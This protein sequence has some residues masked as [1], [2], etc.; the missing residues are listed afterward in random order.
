[1]LEIEGLSVEVEGKGIV[2]DISVNVD[3]GETLVLFGPNGSGKTTLLMAIMG[4][5]RYRVTKGRIVFKGQDITHL[6]VDERARMGIGILF[7][8]PPV[9][10][11]VK[12]RE[13][14]R[15]CLG[16][17]EDGYVIDEM[18]QRLNL[19]DLLDREV[20]YG[21]SGGEVKRS[22]LLQLM[23]QSPEFI[24]LDEPDSGV[25]LVN[26]SLV[27]EMINELLQE[28]R[29][30]SR[31]KSGLIITHTGHILDYVN[32]DR[33]CV[34]LYGG[35]WC[36]GNPRQILSSIKTHGYEGCAVCQK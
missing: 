27:G 31:T 34:L 17:R 11:G 22:E 16:E 29:M 4:F 8:R 21:F 18:A 5:P 6:P 7:Q 10:R 23:A 20:N 35:I 9:V 13:M 25:D 36:R 28:D 2:H 15:A 1:M 12:M 30:R 26:I 3:I 33:A 19:V 32:A 24:L 14:V